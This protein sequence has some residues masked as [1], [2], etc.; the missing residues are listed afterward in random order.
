MKTEH[1][2][3]KIWEIQSHRGLLQC[4]VTG[5]SSEALVS[6]TEGKWASG[7]LSGQGQCDARI[8]PARTICNL[9]LNLTWQQ[10]PT[11]LK[12]FIFELQSQGCLD[13]CPLPPISPSYMA[14]VK[15]SLLYKKNGPILSPLSHLLSFLTCLPLLFK[16][17]QSLFHDVF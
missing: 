10:V 2:K 16:Q 3:C 17:L 14:D 1:V 8:R 13:P 7:S 4:Q 9:H 6:V 11:V 12:G 15:L 5:H